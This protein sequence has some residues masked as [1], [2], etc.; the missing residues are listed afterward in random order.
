MLLICS[1]GNLVKRRNWVCLVVRFSAIWAGLGSLA[2]GRRVAGTI[3]L[4]L[5]R[6]IALS[7]AVGIGFVWY[8]GSAD[9]AEW[10][11]FGGEAAAP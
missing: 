5:A 6:A 9:L 10:V 2:G 1:A 8:T 4:S 3:V 11:F 7:P